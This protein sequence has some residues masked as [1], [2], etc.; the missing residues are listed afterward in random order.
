[1][2]VRLTHVDGKLPNLALVY[3]CADCVCLW[4]GCDA[5]ELELKQSL[6]VPLIHLQ[7]RRMTHIEL[8]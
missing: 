3:S 7:G 6:Q 8:T 2:K 5:D 4:R 1:M